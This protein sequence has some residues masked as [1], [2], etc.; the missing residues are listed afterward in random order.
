MLRNTALERTETAE[1]RDRLREKFEI[2]L[3][4]STVYMDKPK[5]QTARMTLENSR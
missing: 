1:Y 2:L 5:T 3:F 4:K